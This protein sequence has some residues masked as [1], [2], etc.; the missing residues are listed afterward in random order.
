MWPWDPEVEGSWMCIVGLFTLIVELSDRARPVKKPVTKSLNAR[1]THW[2]PKETN[3][4]TWSR[5]P[6]EKFLTQTVF[7]RSPLETRIK[8]L[9][10]EIQQIIVTKVWQNRTII[11][12]TETIKDFSNF[13]ERDYFLSQYL[14]HTLLTSEGEQLMKDTKDAVK[15]H[16]NVALGIYSSQ[17]RNV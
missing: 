15:E 10:L 9:P 6:R 16:E 12:G 1:F 2:K 7:A 3:L 11:E 13:V 8:T 5:F 4:H 17:V 14:E